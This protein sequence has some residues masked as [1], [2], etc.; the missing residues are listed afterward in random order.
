MITGKGAANVPLQMLQGPSLGRKLGSSSSSS[1]LVL[2][3][4]SSNKLI[5]LLGVLLTGHSTVYS[6]VREL[7]LFKMETTNTTSGKKMGFQV[8][9]L[10]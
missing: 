7:S 10:V 1:K 9:I 6:K 8:A 2:L 3:L 5:L 4:G